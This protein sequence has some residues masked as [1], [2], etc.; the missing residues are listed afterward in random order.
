MEIISQKWSNELASKNL[1]AHSTSNYGENIALEYGSISSNF[2][3]CIINAIKMWYSEVN[4]YDYLNPGYNHT[5]GHFTQL[6]WVNTRKISVGISLS[7]KTNIIY[8][9]MNF[10]PPGNYVGAINY[11][12]NVLPPLI[13]TP[14]TP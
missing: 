12:N 10:D 2:S 5:A 8:I 11:I 14:I 13:Q 9:V 3:I 4:N 7:N 6:I 1:F